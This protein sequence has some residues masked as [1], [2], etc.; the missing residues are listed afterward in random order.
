ML[1]GSKSIFA[2]FQFTRQEVYVSTSVLR[3]KVEH[4]CIVK[5]KEG[6]GRKMGICHIFFSTFQRKKVYI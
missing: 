4:V 5:N 1:K 6:K 2:N 3:K